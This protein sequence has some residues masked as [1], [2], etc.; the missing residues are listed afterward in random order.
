MGIYLFLAALTILIGLVLYYSFYKIPINHI[1]AVTVFGITK[2]DLEA[3]YAHDADIEKGKIKGSKRVNLITRFASII[4]PLTGSIKDEGWSFVFL[5]GFITDLILQDMRDIVFDCIID[6]VR[7]PDK[8]ESKIP[9]HFTINPDRDNLYQFFRAGGE[10]GIKKQIT[11]MM[12]ERI[13]EWA[14]A[15][16]E[17]PQTWEEL[18]K[19]QL[20]ATDVLVKRIIGPGESIS[21]IPDEAQSIPT[22][23]LLKYYTN[24]RP[25][26]EPD[27]D[28]GSLSPIYEWSKDN[29]TGLEEELKEI[30]KVKP[31]IRVELKEAVEKRRMEISNIRSGKGNILASSLG[32]ITSRMNIGEI[33]LLGETA[34]AAEL[35][36]KE[37][38]QK[39]GERAEFK[40]I[41]EIFKE[42]TGKNVLS[43]D[44]V[45]EMIQIERGKSTKVV[46]E[47]KINVTNLPESM[48]ELVKMFTKG[49]NK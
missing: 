24:P 44:K 9:I 35:K 18:S 41:L 5:K 43:E 19:S 21:E 36:A 2:Y 22:S 25:K 33:E 42:H 49:G 46:H 38:Q 45:W 8:A 7:T 3:R 10:N 48:E 30:E 40:H 16:Q 11:G 28:N 31:N 4:F 34:K 14:F 17:G 32:V 13:R 26:I 6:K 12:E 20:E 27:P 29:W 1:A 15:D 23:V 39:D 37:K 47:H